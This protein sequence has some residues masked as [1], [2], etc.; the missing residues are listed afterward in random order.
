MKQGTLESEIK[1]EIKDYIEEIGGFWSAVAGGAYSKP[2]DPDLIACINGRF[3][4]IEGKTPSGRISQAQ[5]ER[6]EEI[7]HANGYYLIVRSKADFIDQIQA[8]RIVQ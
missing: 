2:G 8:L 7:E 4:G 6:K 5:L 3:V 1:K